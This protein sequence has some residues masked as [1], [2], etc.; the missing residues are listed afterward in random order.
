MSTLRLPA[1]WQDTCTTPLDDHDQPALFIALR[2]RP[3]ARTQVQQPPVREQRI[4][5]CG[6]SPRSQSHSRST[7]SAASRDG[8]HG[9]KVTVV[10]ICFKTPY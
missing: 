9:T 6:G 2:L 10:T 5:Q 3:L 8:R 7:L 1:A 4:D